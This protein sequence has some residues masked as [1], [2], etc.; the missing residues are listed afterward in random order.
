MTTFRI[1]TKDELLAHLDSALRYKW[2]VP[3]R[4]F[5]MET[6]D[7]RTETGVR[8]KQYG[9]SKVRLDAEG[10]PT[11]KHHGKVERLRASVMTLTGGKELVCDVRLDSDYL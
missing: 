9:R 4:H 1:A 8:H 10:Y 6:V 3:F 2:R 5:T 7:C 11:V